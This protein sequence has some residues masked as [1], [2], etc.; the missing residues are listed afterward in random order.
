MRWHAVH[1]MSV[2]TGMALLG[3]G[4]I[5]APDVDRGILGRWTWVESTG[6]IAGITQTPSSTGETRSLRFDGSVV[7]TFRDGQLLRTDAY[8]IRR[9]TDR[10]GFEIVYQ[11]SAAA[12]PSQD[13][14]LQDHTLVLVDPCCDGF[15]SRYQRATDVVE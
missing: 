15:T 13:V 3:C 6:G 10:E 9:T 2:L 4:E 11:G 12:F 7:E 8:S 5:T 14:D 1:A